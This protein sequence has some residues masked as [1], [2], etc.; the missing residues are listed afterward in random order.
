VRVPVG[1]AQAELDALG[2]AVADLDASRKA[3]LAA[4]EA[5]AAGAT[6]LDAADEACATGQRTLAA[7]AR[8]TARATLPRVDAALATYAG[9]LDAYR[10][11]LQALAPAA[12][13]LEPA[14][15]RALAAL[16]AAGEQEA[17]ALAAFAE[18]ARGAWPAYRDLDEA[19]STWLDRASAGWY[20]DDA[21]AAGGYVV[22]RRPVLPALEKAR[23]SLAKADAARRPATDRMRRELQT[24]N[25]ALESLRGPAE[26]PGG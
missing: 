25:A 1:P 3:L 16:A 4:P 13:P 7:D 6:A 21:E 11:T 26:L 17:A 5:V 15:R 9:Q 20:R 2:R 23:G 14:Q 19:Q 10:S 24:A 22:L 12:A 18:S 8:R